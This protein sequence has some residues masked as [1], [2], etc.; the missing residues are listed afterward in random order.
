[1]WSRADARRVI[2]SIRARSGVGSWCAGPGRTHLLMF[3][4]S[5]PFHS[6]IALPFLAVLLLACSPCISPSPPPYYANPIPLYHPTISMLTPI[7]FAAGQVPRVVA[8][9]SATSLLHLTPFPYVRDD[10][11][12][13]EE[14][15]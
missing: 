15:A 14:D 1:M 5:L 10:D 2:S 8:C 3:F 6:A 13:E 4:Y 9:A 7:R 12:E 11:K